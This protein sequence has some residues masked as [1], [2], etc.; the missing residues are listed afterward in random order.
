MKFACLPLKWMGSAKM[1]MLDTKWIVSV[2]LQDK[3]KVKRGNT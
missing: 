2:D 1:D 3:W